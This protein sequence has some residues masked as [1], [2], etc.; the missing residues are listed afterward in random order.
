MEAGAAA[1]PPD[2]IVPIPDRLPSR[3]NLAIRGI[4]LI[5]MSCPFCKT[6][7]EDIDHS[8][9]RCPYVP[10]VLIKTWSWWNLTPPDSFPSFFISDALGNFLISPDGCP[11]LSKVMQGVFQCSLW[12]IWKWRNKLVDS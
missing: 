6:E 4:D 9:I 8:L 5:S 3:A 10:K 1:A 12:T 7:L 2:S 11:R